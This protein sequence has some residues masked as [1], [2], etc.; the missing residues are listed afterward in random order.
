MADVS[1]PAELSAD[2]LRRLCA[3][4]RLALDIIDALDAFRLRS[5]RKR[6]SSPP[7]ARG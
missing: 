5:G 3:R 7:E 6:A 4:K 1:P 2:R